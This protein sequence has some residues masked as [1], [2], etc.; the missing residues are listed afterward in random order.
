[1]TRRIEAIAVGAAVLLFGFATSARAQNSSANPT[2]A[3]SGEGRVIIPESAIEHP[4]DIG[5]R[6]HTPLRIFVPASAASTAQPPGEGAGATVEPAGDAD[7][8]APTPV[9]S[10]APA[11]GA[12]Q[13]S[14]PPYSGYAFETPASIACLYSLATKIAGCNPNT[15]SAHATGGGKAIAIVDAYDDPNAA[16]DLA[17]FSKQFGL[18]AANFS[19]VFAASAKCDSSCDCTPPSTPCG[20][21]QPAQDPSGGWELEESLDIEWS[22]AMAPGAKSF[23]VEAASSCYDDLKTAEACAGDKVAV[24]GGGEVSNSWGGGEFPGQTA[25]D[26]NF[27]KAGVVYFASSGDSPGVLWPGTSPNVV[28]AGGTTTARNATTGNFLYELSWDSAGGGVSS[29]EARPT[30]QNTVSA[31]VGTQRGVPDLSA[32][33]NPVT[34]VWVLDNFGG[35]YPGP[36]CWYVIGGTSVASPMLAGIVNSAGH[37][38]ASSAAELATIYA[39]RAVAADFHDLTKGFCGPYSGYAAKTGWDFCTGVGSNNGKAGK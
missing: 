16:A 31:M 26:S 24:A 6:A 7:V 14:G 21:P 33:S 30:Y 22:H 23:L 5:V 8:G 13:S 25:Y 37:F 11:G 20:G 34:G 15:V 38:A 18:P 10:F 35:C 9:P 39:N 3:K 28:S 17:A 12:P 19:R 36:P 27:V 32:D 2:P 4:G 1:M 29:Y